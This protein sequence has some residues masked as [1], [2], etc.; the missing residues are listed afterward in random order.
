MKSAT[1][2][3]IANVEAWAGVVEDLLYLVPTDKRAAVLALA[4]FSIISKTS[5]DCQ[6]QRARQ[7][8]KTH[9]VDTC[10]TA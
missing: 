5:P 1:E 8:C 9:A 10:M 3:D 6:K 2:K 7:G 4:T